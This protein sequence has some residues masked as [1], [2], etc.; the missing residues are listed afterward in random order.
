MRIGVP[1]EIKVHENRVGL[2]PDSVAELTTMGADVTVQAGAGAGVGYS[3]DHY[4]RAGA[5]IGTVQQAFAADLVVKVKEPLLHEC[6]RLRSG[7]LLRPGF[8]WLL[9]LR[10]AGY[11]R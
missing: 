10:L 2:S 3:D 7:Q 8:R 9:R 5:R 1:K 6:E 4:R 11:F